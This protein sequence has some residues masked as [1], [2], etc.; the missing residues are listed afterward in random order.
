MTREAQAPSLEH[1]Q[2]EMSDGEYIVLEA[3]VE[4]VARKHSHAVVNTLRA[5]ATP[6][7]FGTLTRACQGHLISEGSS[8]NKQHG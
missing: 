2:L 7:P 5:Y 6:G 8:T 1:T 3:R 4:E